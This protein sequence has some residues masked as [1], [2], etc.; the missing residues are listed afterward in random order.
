MSFENIPY[1]LRYSIDEIM[2]DARKHITVHYLHN[3][4]H[5]AGKPATR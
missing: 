3:I 4:A 5:S 1:H 2:A